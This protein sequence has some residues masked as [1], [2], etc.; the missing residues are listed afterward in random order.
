[1]YLA[2]PL[3][4]TSLPTR[5]IDVGGLNGALCCDYNFAVNI[6]FQFLKAATNETATLL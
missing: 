3:K 2:T 5:M 1:M 4:P 6:I